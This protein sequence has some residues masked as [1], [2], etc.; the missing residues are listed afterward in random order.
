MEPITLAAITSAVTILA[1]EAGKSGASEAGKSTWIE[2][3]KRLG[4]SPNPNE[5]DLA[6]K[7]AEKLVERPEAARDIVTLLQGAPND[8]GAARTLVGSINAENVVVLGTMTG[9]TFN[10]G[11]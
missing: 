3:R 5:P 4:W 11:G 10:M 2:I 7:I 8:I 9:G 1:T 6:R